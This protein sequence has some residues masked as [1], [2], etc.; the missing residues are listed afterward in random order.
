MLHHLHYY[1]LCA[2]DQTTTIPCLSVL[3]IFYL[4]HCVV[5]ASKVEKKRAEAKASSEWFTSSLVEEKS[6]VIPSGE[7]YSSIVCICRVYLGGFQGFCM[8]Q[9]I[10]REIGT[11]INHPEIYKSIKQQAILA[12]QIHTK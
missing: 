9:K 8:P 7:A 1:Q 12:A 2:H 10:C 3:F 4:L 5:Q 11:A 6:D